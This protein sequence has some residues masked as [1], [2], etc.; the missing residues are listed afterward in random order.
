[1]KWRQRIQLDRRP[2]SLTVMGLDIR[3]SQSTSIPQITLLIQRLCRLHCRSFCGPPIAARSY[4]LIVAAYSS[5]RYRHYFQLVSQAGAS[6]DS[7]TKLPEKSDENQNAEKNKIGNALPMAIISLSADHGMYAGCYVQLT[8]A[9][10]DFLPDS[11]YF[12]QLYNCTSTLAVLL[13]LLFFL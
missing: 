6:V 5:G 12:D 4:F 1:M 3:M 8:S 7:Q 2:Q 9:A 13:R 10:N 11:M